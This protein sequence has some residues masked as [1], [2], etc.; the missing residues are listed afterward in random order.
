MCLFVDFRQVLKDLVPQDLARE[1]A[2]G[3][4]A[5]VRQFVNCEVGCNEKIST[6]VTHVTGL[7]S[8]LRLY[9]VMITNAVNYNLLQNIASAIQQDGNLSAD[10]AKITFLKI[11]YKWPTFGSAFF[12][13]KVLI[14]NV[15]TDY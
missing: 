8:L 7:F 10:D 14:E 11:I 6:L 2:A 9:S 13:V 12:E 5:R 3:E 4:W 1:M 15:T